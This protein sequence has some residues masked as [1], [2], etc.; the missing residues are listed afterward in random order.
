VK[1]FRTFQRRTGEQPGPPPPR[2][3]SGEGRGDTQ[4][5]RRRIAGRL[6]ACGWPTATTRLRVSLV[7]ATRV[8]RVLSRRLPMATLVA[9]GG[10]AVVLADTP[11]PSRC[12]SPCHGSRRGPPARVDLGLPALLTAD[13]GH[14]GPATRPRHRGVPVRHPAARRQLFRS[15][16]RRT[17]RRSRPM[18]PPVR[19]H[20]HSHARTDH[21]NRPG[22]SGLPTPPALRPPHRA[23]H[24]QRRRIGTAE[25][26]A[27]RRMLFRCRG[28]LPPSSGSSV[29]TCAATDH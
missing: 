10:T 17:P 26:L 25:L 15:L 22:I 29:A 20:L 27:C 11:P 18:V 1:A 5:C 19:T 21:R 3:S 4:T 7:L 24:R 14:L 28:D 6:D 9:V 13:L 23:Y 16:G 2:R 12:T 8:V